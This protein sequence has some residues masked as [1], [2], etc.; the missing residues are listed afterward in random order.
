MDSD[1]VV[2]TVRMAGSLA[3][4][5][6]RTAVGSKSRLKNSRWT[7]VRSLQDTTERVRDSD[8][9]WFLASACRCAVSLLNGVV[10]Q[11][12]GLHSTG[13]G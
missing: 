12:I 7:I 13:A 8:E 5:D 6:V 3:Q 10:L 1:Q 4:R 9:K 2:A 11:R